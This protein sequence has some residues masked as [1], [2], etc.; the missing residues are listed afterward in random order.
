MYNIITYLNR[1]NIDYAILKGKYDQESFQ[2]EEKRFQPDLDIV[3]LC[4]RQ[5]F[6]DNIKQDDKYQ[7]IEAN[8]F[9]DTENK[10]RIDFYFKTLNVGYYHYLFV[11]KQSFVNKEVSESEYILYQILDPLLKFSK[12]HNRHQFR[13]QSY[14]KNGVDI[15][16]K[17]LL[18][19]IVGR[20]LANK[21][22]EKIS[23]N[24]FYL[25]RSFIRKCKCNMLFING[26][27]VKMI[28]ARLFL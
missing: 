7:Q 11:S 2:K 26:N 6:I 4:E 8:S 13:L 12:Y 19:N 25:S 1:H 28:K 27:F 15:E 21:L 9:F 10:I 17:N 24:E 23:K 5:S 22:L 18:R 16:T 20:A 14:F 3:L